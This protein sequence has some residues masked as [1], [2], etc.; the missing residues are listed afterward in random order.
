MENA[1]KETQ[2]ELSIEDVVKDIYKR[3]DNIHAV[4]GYILEKIKNEEV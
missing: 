3:L 4:L 2:T 1:D